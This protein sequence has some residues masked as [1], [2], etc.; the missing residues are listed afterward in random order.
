MTRV[1]LP[2]PVAAAFVVLGCKG[3]EA[4]MALESSPSPLSRAQV[5]SGGPQGRSTIAGSAGGVAFGDVEAA[6]MIES[7]DSDATTVV[8]LFSKP[9]RCVDLSFSGWDH[10]IPTGTMVLQL[11][12]FGNAPGNFLSVTTT[13]LA[14]REAV[15]EC[16][17]TSPDGAQNDVISG[18][19]WITLDSLSIRGAATGSFTL[20]FGAGELTGTFNAA[21]CA[22]G[23]EP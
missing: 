21:F 17:R 4:S 20:E 12:V 15:A 6:F 19:G 13:P 2:W 10:T 18:G 22:D 9:V 23:H 8:Y 14:A 7:P 11:K 1:R 5:D 3:R 16:M